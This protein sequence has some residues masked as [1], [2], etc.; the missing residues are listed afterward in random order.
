MSMMKS[1]TKPKYALEILSALRITH[2]IIPLETNANENI[3][4]Y[5]HPTIRPDWRRGKILGDSGTNETG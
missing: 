2:T 1:Q 3:F 4:S 5:G